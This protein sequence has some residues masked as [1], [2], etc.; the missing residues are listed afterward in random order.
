MASEV[1]S[2]ALLMI[3]TIVATVALIN[4]VIPSIYSMSGSITSVTHN[5]NEQMKTDVKFIYETAD[6]SNHLTAWV[7]NT[8]QTQ[9]A[10]TN[11]NHTDV[12]FG[13]ANGVMTRAQLNSTEYPNWSF[14]LENDNGDGQWDPG[15]TLRIDITAPVDQPF[16]SGTDYKVRLTLYNGAFCEDYFTK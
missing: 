6:D 9:L 11:F 14:T 4:A 5:V 1:I 16:V 2:S 15:E 13:D 8:G 7:K 10:L 12:F 3:A